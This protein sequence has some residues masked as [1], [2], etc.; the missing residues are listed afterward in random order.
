VDVAITYSDRQLG[1][2]IRDD[3]VGIPPSVLAQ[4]SKE[5]HFG[6]IGMRERAK[7]IGGALSIDSGAGKGTDVMLTLPARLAY[8]ER[9]HG[10][11]SH[12]PGRY[13]RERMDAN[14]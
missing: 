13:A 14:G 10:W 8:A 3:G 1:V 6:L 5:G 4:G 12:L 9:T 2:Q 7:R 11:H